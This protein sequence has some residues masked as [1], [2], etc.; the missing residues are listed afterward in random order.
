MTKTRRISDPYQTMS[1]PSNAVPEGSAG[2]ASYAYTLCFM[3]SA[4]SGDGDRKSFLQGGNYDFGAGSMGDNID[5]EAAL[6]GLS[7]HPMEVL[8]SSYAKGGSNPS[9]QSNERKQ[10]EHY[11]RVTTIIETGSGIDDGGSDRH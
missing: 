8:S 6:C 4:S 9:L 11:C 1:A 10:S 7:P 2:F 3:Q 5:M